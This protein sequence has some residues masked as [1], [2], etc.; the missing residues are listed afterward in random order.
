[1]IGIAH[2]HFNAG[3][4][5]EAA[6]WADK[7]IQS[8]PYFLSGLLVATACYVEAGRLDDAQKTKAAV[9]RLSPGY[10]VRPA[11]SGPI[12]SL[13]ADKRYRE[14]ILKAGLPE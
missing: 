9:L 13:K 3:R 12:R 6:L 8:F 2:G 14:A 4:Y 5:D 1:M 10:R 11:G 7:S